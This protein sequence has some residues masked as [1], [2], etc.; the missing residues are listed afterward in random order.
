MGKILYLCLNE[1]KPGIIGVLM[2]S[3]PQTKARALSY[4]YMLTTLSPFLLVPPGFNPRDS[5]P[6]GIQRFLIHSGQG[7]CGRHRVAWTG[8]APHDGS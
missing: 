2:P 5:W 1:K 7:F 3:G 4:R 8:G 6:Q